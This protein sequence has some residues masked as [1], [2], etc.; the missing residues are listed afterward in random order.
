MYILST[1]AWSAETDGKHYVLKSSRPSPS[2]LCAESKVA[3]QLIA[4]R[5][6]AIEKN[7]KRHVAFLS[8]ACG[9]I[10]KAYTLHG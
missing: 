1:I 4:G 8:R 3:T 2:F 6:K 7:M 10:L 9:A 5:E